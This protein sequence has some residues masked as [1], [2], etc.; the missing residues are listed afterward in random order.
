MNTFID[1]YTQ[2]KITAFWENHPCG[3]DFIETT[4]WES[5]FKEY[6]KYKYSFEPHIL[7]EIAKVDFK[8]KRVLEIGLGQGAETQKIIEKGAIYNGIDI[9]NESVNR[10][11]LRCKLFNC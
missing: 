3:V 4:E 5:F 6:D 11:K 9:T 2:E 1:N 10:V 8:N 7:E